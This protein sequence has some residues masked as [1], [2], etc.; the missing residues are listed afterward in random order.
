MTEYPDD[1]RLAIEW[2]HEADREHTIA[3]Q[4]Y[5]CAF[6]EAYIQQAEKKREER[7]SS[8]SFGGQVEHTIATLSAMEARKKRDDWML[9]C[10]RRGNWLAY[11]I[12]AKSLVPVTYDAPTT[13]TLR[14]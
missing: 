2:F 12:G 8:L 13:R 10:T 14:R 5:D 11:R 1:V 6:G 3:C 9:E 4:E 7:F